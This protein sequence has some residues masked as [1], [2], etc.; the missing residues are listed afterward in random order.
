VSDLELVPVQ[1]SAE[2]TTAG[3]ELLGPGM[4]VPVHGVVAAA[5]AASRHCKSVL[6]RGHMSLELGACLS[7]LGLKSLSHA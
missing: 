3:P 2:R 6:P 7:Q 1:P 4:G 5:V